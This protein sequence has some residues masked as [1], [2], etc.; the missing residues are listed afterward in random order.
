MKPMRNS[1]WEI[2]PS[3]IS[4]KVYVY[5]LSFKPNTLTII[6]GALGLIGLYLIFFNLYRYSF[7]IG[8]AFI[9]LFLILDY[10][11]GD[12][13]RETGQQS[14]I[15]AW[16]DPFIDK[17]MEGLILI[18]VGFY[19]FETTITTQT[20]LMLTFSI[21]FFQLNQFSL[22]LD[23]ENRNRPQKI[24]KIS[25]SKTD[26]LL[27]ISF[28]LRHASLGHSALVITFIFLINV[29]LIEYLTI[30]YFF[31][32]FFTLVPT[33]SAKAKKLFENYRV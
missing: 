21:L 24:K 23:N 29:G 12:V 25:T 14:E 30:L 32:S 11:D 26:G 18:T 19:A 31:W 10:V 1:I 6:S 16:L 9:I 28:F 3:F 20:Y 15:G 2:A 33:I 17:L 4:S 8:S 22:V 27:P 13:A 5:F 7:A